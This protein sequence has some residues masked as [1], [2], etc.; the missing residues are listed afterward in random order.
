MP[1][2]PT[3]IFPIEIVEE[4]FHHMEVRELLKCTLVNTRWNQI[5]GSSPRIMDKVVI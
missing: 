1:I 3:L 2:D 5:I 4:I